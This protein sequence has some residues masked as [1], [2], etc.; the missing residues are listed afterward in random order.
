GSLGGFGVVVVVVVVGGGGVAVEAPRPRPRPQP[1]RRRR[2]GNGLLRGGPRGARAEHRL[3]PR[4]GQGRR[5]P[6]P[7]PHPA[8]A[9]AGS[10]SD[11]DG[12]RGSTPTRSPGRHP[13]GVPTAALCASLTCSESMTRSTS[14]KLRPVPL[15]CAEA[16]STARSGPSTYTHREAEGR[17]AA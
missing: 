16:Y 8:R 6:L 12:H 9:G 13:A 3:Y 7:P 14:A 1:Q 5:D 2:T 4:E 11:G 10:A 17:P 15:G